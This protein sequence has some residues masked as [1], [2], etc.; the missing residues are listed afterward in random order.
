[1][2]FSCR[3]CGSNTI[4]EILDLGM[5]PWGNDFIPIS[6][7]KISQLY[8]LKFVICEEC[9][10]CQIDY[11]IPKEKMFVNH[12]YMSGTTK[13]LKKHFEVVGEKILKKIKFEKNDY[14]LDIGGN[15]GTFLKFFKNKNINVLNVDSGKEQANLSNKVGIKCINNFFEEK[16]SKEIK[17]NY[18][19]AK[20]IHGSG[21]FFH[22]EDLKSVFKG[23]KKLLMKDGI[24]VAE[25]IYLPSMIKNLAFDQIYHEHLLYY[26]L[27]SLQN[28]LDQF[29]LEIIDSELYEIHGGSC[30]AYIAH[31][32]NNKPKTN[33]YLNM[34][35]NEK[36]E[37]FLDQKVYLDFSDKVHNIKNKMRRLFKDLKEKNKKIYALGAPVKGSTLLNFI[38]LDE[39]HL[40]CAVEINPH[41]FD[42]F[43]PGTKIKVLDQSL[44]QD[45]DYYLFLSWNFQKEIISKMSSFV[46][47]GGKFIIPFPDVKIL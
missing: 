41:K 24:L 6:E 13:T 14:I 37:G 45:P 40:E 30:V 15:D 32:T 47:K 4:N 43:Y 11:T 3:V 39:N 36:K 38:E 25:F 17:S 31:K 26:S 7:N 8:P 1:M 19:Q 5:Q 2:S 29:D 33:K 16:I 10:T 23:I 21:I 22:L 28:L 18:N 20:V 34:L 9:K 44:V 12:S 35:E 27:H 46:E 42:T